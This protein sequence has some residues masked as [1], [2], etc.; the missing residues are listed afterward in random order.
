MEILH[1]T[2]AKKGNYAVL[3]QSK[4]TLCIYTGNKKLYSVLT[5]N[6]IYVLNIFTAIINEYFLSLLQK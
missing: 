6:Y 4:R 2:T 3:Q 5:K 1:F